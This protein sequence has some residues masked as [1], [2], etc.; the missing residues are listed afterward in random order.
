[1]TPSRHLQRTSL[2]RQFPRRFLDFFDSPEAWFSGERMVPVE[3]F[4]DEGKL[5]VRAEL[6]GVDPDKDVEITVEDGALT[7]HAER[8]QEET[9]ELKD[10]YRSEFRYGSFS[11]TVMLPPGAGP[12][13]VT[14]TYDDGVLEVRIPM[15]TPP[16]D[17]RTVPVTRR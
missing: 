10:G 17:R 9:T 15:A 3:E 13:D 6:P 16:V 11:R 12:D 8:R 2:S 4:M 14:A 5:V 1:M 7:L